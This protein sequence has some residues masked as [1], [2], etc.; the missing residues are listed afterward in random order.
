M[1]PK[2]FEIVPVVDDVVVVVG[3][4]VVDVGDEVVAEGGVELHVGVAIHHCPV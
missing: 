2:T 1:G 4:S 3:P